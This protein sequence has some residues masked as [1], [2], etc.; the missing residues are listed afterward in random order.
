L[1]V[2]RPRLQ[3]VAERYGVAVP[4]PNWAD[5]D[6]FGEKVEM[7]LEERISAVSF[8]FGMPEPKVIEAFRAGG[9]TVIVTVTTAEEARAAVNAGADALCV[10]GPEA[11]G[12][13]STHRM[14]DQ[15]GRT[16]LCEQLRHTRGGITVLV[17][18]DTPTGADIAAALAA[19][20]TA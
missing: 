11:G 16:S 7:L 18:G 17:S 20:A 2:Y 14:T 10:Q 8:T 12:H 9:S 4:E 15:P 13:R 6:F 5:D 1:R 19:G 3:P